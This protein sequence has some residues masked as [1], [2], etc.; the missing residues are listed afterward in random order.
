VG[1]VAHAAVAERLQCGVLGN[2]IQAA[3]FFPHGA[4]EV[5]EHRSVVE[6]VFREVELGLWA[7]TVAPFASTAWWAEHELRGR[8]VAD[9][10]VEVGRAL[11]R[12]AKRVFE[13][14]RAF[15]AGVGHRHAVR[16]GVPVDG[17]VGGAAHGAHAM[18]PVPHGGV[19]VV[20]DGVL[21][22]CDLV[23]Q[24]LVCL[25]VHLVASIPLVRPL[26]VDQKHVRVRRRRVWRWWRRR[27]RGRRQW[28][29]HR[30]RGDCDARTHGGCEQS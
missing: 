21:L 25:G 11:G 14:R 27:R 28:W 16:R 15:E 29:R 30:T 20:R 23:R 3:P 8:R 10:K 18:R 24:L 1:N 22:H 5:N 17:Q 2:D 26:R 7:H 4:V 6:L 9:D 19:F 12:C 13:G